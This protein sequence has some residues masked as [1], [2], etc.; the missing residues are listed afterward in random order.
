VSVLGTLRSWFG[1]KAA[2]TTTASNNNG[3]GAAAS[4]ALALAEIIQQEAKDR[5]IGADAK[6]FTPDRIERVL[7]GAMSGN[8]VAQWQLYDLMEGTWPELQKC[9]NQ[10]KGKVQSLE[11]SVQPYAPRGEDPSPEAQ[12]RAQF[13]EEAIWNMSPLPDRDEND[14]E[15]TIGDIM[16]AW[17]KGLSVLEVHWDVRRYEA[18]TIFAPRATTWV[19][20]RHYGYPQDDYRLML[21]TR[22]SGFNGVGIN[23]SVAGRSA[24]GATTSGATTSGAT[25]IVTGW[26]FRR[27]SF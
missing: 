13:L 14:F 15:L 23:Q 10:L 9:L 2:A 25:A 27:T 12:R 18:G 8:L 21:N 1:V 5:W 26:S 24:T 17:G 16:D 19:H 3:N 22:E 20:P 11:W 7:R 4:K 6:C